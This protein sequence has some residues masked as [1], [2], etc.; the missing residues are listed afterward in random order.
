MKVYKSLNYAFPT[1][2]TATEQGFGDVGCWFVATYSYDEDRPASGYDHS[3]VA[4]FAGD[5]A[6]REQAIEVWKQLDYPVN[7]WSCLTQHHPEWISQG[8]EEVQHGKR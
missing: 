3:V 4:A 6:G 8:N 2:T 7:V 1:S 5:S